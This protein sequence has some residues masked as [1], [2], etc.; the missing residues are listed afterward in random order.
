[1]IL[2]DSPYKGNANLG[3]VLE[4]AEAG[5]GEDKQGYRAEF[6]ELVKAARGPVEG[7]K[8]TD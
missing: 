1:M 2:R 3:S 5:K 7:K 8:I 6:I 4:L